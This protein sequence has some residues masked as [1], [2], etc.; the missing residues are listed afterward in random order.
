MLWN[1]YWINGYS[2]KMYWSLTSLASFSVLILSRYLL[3]YRSIYLVSQVY[4]K[5]T[6]S[7]VRLRHTNI[8]DALCNL[9]RSCRSMK[10]PRSMS[11]S[12]VGVDERLYLS[13]STTLIR[14]PLNILIHSRALRCGQRFCPYLA[15]N[16]WWTSAPFIPSD[17]R[18]RTIACCFP[19]CKPP[20]EQSS[21]R[22]AH[23]AQADYN[24]TTLAARHHLTLSYSM[25]RSQ[26][27]FQSDNENIPIFPF[28]ISFVEHIGCRS[29]CK[30]MS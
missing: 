15:A 27:C 5:T 20:V 28:W 4:C 12:F 13:A 23:S 29:V 18:R 30:N 9:V 17:T 2:I 1:I 11:F 6:P 22:H 24:W 14:L 3:V 8:Y 25:T 16:C 26:Q 19:W 7:F 21:S 10:S